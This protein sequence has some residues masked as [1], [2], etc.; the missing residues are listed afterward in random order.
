[1]IQII[2]GF[3]SN[4]QFTDQNQYQDLRDTS[5]ACFLFRIFNIVAN[6]PPEMRRYLQGLSEKVSVNKVTSYRKW[7]IEKGKQTNI[8]SLI[9][10]MQT[11]FPFHFCTTVDRKAEQ[12]DYTAMNNR[13]GSVIWVLSSFMTQPVAASIFD[14]AQKPEIESTPFSTLLPGGIP[15]K[16]KAKPISVSFLARLSIRCR[17]RVLEHVESVMFPDSTPG[18]PKLSS[19]TVVL[20]PGIVET[21][22][23]LLIIAPGL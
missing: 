3:Y 16:G 11:N 12:L 21:Y 10:R 15:F 2:I 8:H 22:S 17:K 18:A 9:K 1:L 6:S 14:F 5:L 7:W 20:P 19:D 23:R 4:E 13:M